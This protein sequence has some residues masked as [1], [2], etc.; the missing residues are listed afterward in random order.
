MSNNNRRDGAFSFRLSVS[1]VEG[2]NIC[3]APSPLFS[4]ICEN[5]A[6]VLLP[7]SLAL[8]FV[9]RLQ[10]RTNNN[11]LGCRAIQVF[12]SQRTLFPLANSCRDQIRLFLKP[13]SASLS[14]IK[15]I[16]TSKQVSCLDRH[17]CLVIATLPSVSHSLSMPSFQ[18]ARATDDA[19]Q[20]NA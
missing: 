12:V 4:R 20:T 1:V 8:F 15:V 7:S 17:R 3:E 9:A 6:K 13:S 19:T 2:V 14:R 18:R 10:C 5:V 11:Y 16:K